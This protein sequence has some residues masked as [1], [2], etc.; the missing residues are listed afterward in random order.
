MLF[1]QP[2]FLSKHS[3]NVV[4]LHTKNADVSPMVDTLNKTT[5]NLKVELIINKLEGPM[6]K[7]TDAIKLIDRALTQYEKCNLL[8]VCIPMGLKTSYPKLKQATLAITEKR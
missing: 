4:I 3:I 1:G 8:M 2:I 6:F 5:R 7:D